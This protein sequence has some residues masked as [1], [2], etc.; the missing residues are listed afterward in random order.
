MA[1]SFNGGLDCP[2]RAL[3][4]YLHVNFLKPAVSMAPGAVYFFFLYEDLD[5]VLKTAAKNHQ[6]F[7]NGTIDK[8][9]GFLRKDIMLR[10]F[11]VHYGKIVCS[12]LLQFM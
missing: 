5:M 9:H 11:K 8:G 2:H 10:Y 4:H 6:G 3:P 12:C 7:M 1:G